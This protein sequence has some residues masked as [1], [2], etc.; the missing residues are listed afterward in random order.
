MS[1]PATPP[2]GGGLRVVST[3]DSRGRRGFETARDMVWSMAAVFL[4]VIVVLVLAWPPSPDPI[5]PVEWRPVISA[6]AD[7][8]EW[9]VMAPETQWPGW[10]ATSARV[11]PI[12]GGFRVVHVGWVTDD[13]EYLSVRQVDLAGEAA[14]EW[15]RDEVGGSAP[16]D[17]T[18]TDAAGR[19]WSTYATDDGSALVA[20]IDATTVVIAGTASQQQ[21]QRMAA[22]LVGF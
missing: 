16:T 3:R 14:T 6:V 12:V 8:A 21:M 2:T 22:A 7:S 4:A 5:R 13:E 1:D 17:P 9:P 20:E 19:I 18:W 15:L 10:N 11:E